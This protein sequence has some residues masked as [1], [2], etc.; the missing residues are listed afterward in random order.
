MDY[1]EEDLLAYLQNPALTDDMRAYYEGHLAR[2]RA[3]KEE[4]L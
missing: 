1:T 3:E 2:I 4:N